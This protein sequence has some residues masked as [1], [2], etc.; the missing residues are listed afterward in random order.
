MFAKFLRAAVL[1]TLGLAFS[2]HTPGPGEVELVDLQ[3]RIVIQE[4]NP[5]TDL[6]WNDN[7]A[8]FQFAIVADRTGG[9]RI[10]VFQDAVDKVNLLQPEFVMSVGDLIEGY[11]E[12]LPLLQSQWNEFQGFVDKLE[13]PFFYVPGNHDLTNLV[14]LEEWKRRFGRPYYHFVYKNVLFLCLDSEDP[15]PTHMSEE[16]AAYVARALEENPDVRWT[17]VFQ[18]KP[19]WVYEEDTGWARIEELL[20]GR[21]HTVFAGHFHTYTKHDR[22]DT[23]YFV[24]ATTGGGSSLRGPIF[25]QFDHVVWVTM[26]DGGP[27]VA[28]LMLEGIWD[29]DVRTA[30]TAAIVDALLMG[31]TGIAPMPILTDKKDFRGG[32][33]QLRLTND[34]DLP[35][36]VSGRFQANATLE[37]S[38]AEIETVV[39]PNSVQLVDLE[40]RPVEKKIAVDEIDPLALGWAVSYDMEGKLIELDGTV[41]L[42]VE[43]RLDC[44]K[45]KGKVVDGDLEDWKKLPFVCEEP[46]QVRV[47]PDSWKGA[48]D[49]SFRFGVEYDDD[50][51]YVAVEVTD[52]RLVLDARKDPWGQD[53]VEMRVDARSDPERSRSRGMGENAE[54]LFI[55]LSAG[56]K[57]GEMVFNQREQVESLGVL[58]ACV[59]TDRGFNAEVAIPRKYLDEKQGEEWREF[60]L[61]IAVDDYD[62]PNGPL[63]QLWWRPDWRYEQNYPGSGTFQKR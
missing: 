52:E 9:H 63:A 50:F 31:G 48:A 49:G 57:P 54:F 30:E 55:G 15:P 56:E 58:A 26:T 7:P 41:R 61:N 17:L 3:P 12:N 34:A 35:M 8:N 2:G 33:T 14:Q 62:E 45:G 46:A 22:N 24:L 6:E 39:P 53:G 29:K 20:Q 51:L 59:K 18:H 27:R 36:K 28:N 5:W 19:L 37:V 60:R 13:M 43:R 21:K 4:V 32:T 25:G 47:S 40:L 42:M 16:Q 44:V 10:G 38:P 11:S 1:M 23:D